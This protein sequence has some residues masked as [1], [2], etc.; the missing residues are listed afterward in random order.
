MSKGGI[1]TLCLK[2]EY[3]EYIPSI[4]DIHYSKFDIR[5]FEN[6]YSDQ[7]GCF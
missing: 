1:A 7:T 5:F 6:V 2:I 3:T 4:F